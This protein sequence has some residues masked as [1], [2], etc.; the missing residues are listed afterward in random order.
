VT[1]S[2]PRKSEVFRLALRTLALG[3]TVVLAG[4]NTARQSTYGQYFQFVT[5]AFKQEFGDG[6]ITRQQA[7]SVS[8]ASMGYR[9]N[10]GRELL[11]VLATDTA[12][13]QLWTSAQHIVLV[14]RD[15]RVRR[16]VG[17]PQD[18]GATTAAADMPSP[19]QALKAPFDSV[20]QVDFPDMGL[21]AI[22]MRC[23]ASARGHTSVA[24]LGTA[25]PTMRVDEKC[26]AT[27][28]DWNFTDSFWVDTDTG[29]SWKTIQHLHPKGEVIETE[30]FRPPS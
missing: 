24:I 2:R 14:T 23:R 19:A 30:I 8:F 29:M 9:I 10:G 13:E 4:C 5:A 3:T 27:G 21:Y 12:G 16:T 28:V 18:V 6:A 11:I 1:L 22:G 17:L 7:A 15:G 26:S 25:I 20:R